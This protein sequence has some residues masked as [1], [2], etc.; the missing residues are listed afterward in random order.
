MFYDRCE[1]PGWIKGSITCDCKGCRLSPSSPRNRF[2]LTPRGRA[3]AKK[4]KR[5][6]EDFKLE[7]P[8]PNK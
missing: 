4:G 1:N 8:R 2:M 7:D 6:I 5:A 3:I